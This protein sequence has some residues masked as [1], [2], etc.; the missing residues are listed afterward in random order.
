MIT[1]NLHKT[2]LITVIMGNIWGFALL[3]A[4]AQSDSS[5]LL[6]VSLDTARTNSSDLYI[7]PG[8]TTVIDFSATNEVITSIK[9]G[10]SSRTV[11]STDIPI[12]T[13][14]ARTVYL[15][16]IAPITF[17]GATTSKISN[18]IVKTAETS[19]RQRLY[20]FDLHHRQ[21]M[22][23]SNGIAIVPQA[24]PTPSCSPTWQVRGKTANLFDI[25]RGLQIAIRKKFTS[26]DDP[27]VTKVKEFLAIAENSCLALPEAAQKAQVD[28]ALIGELAAI[29]LEVKEQK[30]TE[31]QFKTRSFK[32]QNS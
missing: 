15:E 14:R 18:L 7:N 2:A 8:R 27:I 29:G 23:E 13:N 1:F 16:A 26:A 21:G 9:L 11:Y 20:V 32:I 10:D 17:P 30:L 4:Q 19:G 22:S 12:E 5:A 24:T 25:E 31:Q 6:T 3:P 28:L